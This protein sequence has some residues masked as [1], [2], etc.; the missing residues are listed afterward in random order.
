MVEDH[1]RRTRTLDLNKDEIVEAIASKT[2]LD[3][4]PN[5][6]EDKPHV[7]DVVVQSTTLSDQQRDKVYN[8]L[9]KGINNPLA[10]HMTP[11]QRFEDKSKPLRPID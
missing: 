3:S 5:R 10:E 7:D 8:D 4:S 11:E 2:V 9:D 6:L 1:K